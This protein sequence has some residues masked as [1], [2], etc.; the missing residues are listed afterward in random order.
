MQVDPNRK[1][2][3]YKFIGNEVMSEIRKK[4]TPSFTQ[5][6]INT[7]SPFTYPGYSLKAGDDKTYKTIVTFLTKQ[8]EYKDLII[9]ED[10]H[11]GEG[12]ILIQFND[13]NRD[14]LDFI[15]QYSSNGNGATNGT[16][17]HVEIE[18]NPASV[19][20]TKSIFDE[21]FEK[22]KGLIRLCG[23]RTGNHY[24]NLVLS[25]KKDG[26]ASCYNRSK[27]QAERMLS[28]LFAI[29]IDPSMGMHTVTSIHIPLST[30]VDYSALFKE[31]YTNYFPAKTLVDQ[32]VKDEEELEKNPI[33]KGEIKYH[34]TP[35]H[36]RPSE[37]PVVALSSYYP[38]SREPSIDNASNA[39]QAMVLMFRGMTGDE[40]LRFIQTYMSVEDTATLIQ[41]VKDELRPQLIEEITPTIREEEKIRLTPIL[42]EKAKTEALNEVKATIKRHLDGNYALC[43]VTNPQV[44]AKKNAD[45][46]LIFTLVKVPIEKVFGD[47]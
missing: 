2:K 34:H 14:A 26:M 12:R 6:P 33:P 4:A 37:T 23:G 21:P 45:G 47:K 3:V 38:P 15:D 17:D 36:N 7:N 46:N 18:T 39:M 10:R 1:D 27:A 42:L 16:M 25:N 9:V 30:E 8:S 22:L 29:G 31:E 40:R 13:K 43:D 11:K 28:F 44:I 32:E 19:V 41:Q 24:T 5:N 20:P 35:H